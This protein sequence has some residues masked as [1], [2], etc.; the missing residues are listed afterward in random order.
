MGHVILGKSF[1]FCEHNGFLSCK[2]TNYLVAD[3]KDDLREY[4]E[5][6]ECAMNVGCY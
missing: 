4:F 6:A 2:G 1:D 5:A 3:G